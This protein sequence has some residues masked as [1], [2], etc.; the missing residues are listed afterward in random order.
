M[1]IFGKTFGIRIGCVPYISIR[2]IPEIFFGFGRRGQV[3]STRS[4]RRMF[5]L[6]WSFGRPVLVQY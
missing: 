4:Y 6:R 3:V 2:C 1:G 5:S